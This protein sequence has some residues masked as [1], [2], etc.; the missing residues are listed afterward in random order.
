MFKQLSHLL[1]SGEVKRLLENF[2]SLSILKLIN[3]ILPFVTLPYLIKVLGFQQYGAIVLSL[4]LIAY[5]QAVT[6]YG[7]N[8]SSTREIAR[9]RHSNNQLSYIYSKTII[10]KIILLILSLICLFALILFIPQFKNDSLVYSLM[11]LILIGQTLFPE[12]FFRGIE[13][14]RY[15]TILDL[16]TKTSFT[17]G[18]FFLIKKPTDYWMYP[19]IY[20]IGS[21]LV[22]IFSHILIFKKYRIYITLINLNRIFI[23]LKINFSLFINQF[24]PNLYNNTTTFLVGF[25]LGNNAAGIFG[26]IRQIVNI[27]GVFNSIVSMVI[28]PYLARKKEKFYLFS[29]FYLFGFF[30]LTLLIIFLHPLIFNWIGLYGNNVSLIFIVLSVGIFFIATYSLYS[31]NFLILRGYD[32]LVMRN[33]FFISIVGLITSYPLIK[34]FGVLGGALNIAIAQLVMGLT[35]YIYYLKFKQI[36]E[37]L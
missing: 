12:W 27:L 34:F 29:K 17:A 20:G 22:S 5:F 3:A 36:G 18:V 14:M 35:A 8:L 10:S 11:C 33:T 30:T 15:I 13:K 7:F 1:K 28:F 19:L 31:T 2:F 9:H 23:N 25:L 16:I 21:I 4:S 32:K 26:A 24:M 6:D 37:I